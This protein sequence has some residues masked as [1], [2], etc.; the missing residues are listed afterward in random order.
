MLT[1]K[2]KFN[3]RCETNSNFD[4][5]NT[6]KIK[7]IAHPLVISISGT[8]LHE[9]KNDKKLNDT[10]KYFYK[11][12]Y[13]IDCPNESEA[14]K[15][16]NFL[17]ASEQKLIAHPNVGGV[18][19]FTRNYISKEQLT[20]LTSHI[21]S[22]AKKANKDNFFICVDHEGGSVQRFKSE[23][24][25]IPPAQT[26]GKIYDKNPTNPKAALSE[27]FDCGYTMAKE[28]KECG[29][30]ISLAP[31][32]DLDLG[33][34][35]ISKLNR[36]FHSSPD[37]AIKLISSFIDG[38]NKA[39][40]MATA[41][42]FPGHGK[43]GIG[44][45]HKILPKD[46]RTSKELEQNDLLVFKT[47][48]EKGKIQAVM[49]AHI[50]YPD[51]DPNFTAGTSKIWLNDILRDKLNFKGVIISDCL[52]MKG[53]FGNSYLDKVKQALNF[54]DIGLFCNQPPWIFL[55]VAEQLSNHI[56]KEKSASN[57]IIM[58]LS[59]NID[60]CCNCKNKI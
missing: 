50:I 22:I 14:I 49:P 11:Q 41:K 2:K 58:W 25:I 3:A 10:E 44:D 9:D 20:K 26:F 4:A 18:I 51:V 38:M 57:K 5:N 59:E 48:I 1:A 27:A 54:G 56:I 15:F 24:T 39:G 8:Q 19:L 37:I 17:K 16:K 47:L 23:F 45:S 13:K 46:D 33:N 28:L 6:N 12:K 35:A 60:D 55:D 7:T 31:V 52:S 42:H 34:K 53:A 30:D 43:G 21:K 40:M 29:V 36:A 32:C